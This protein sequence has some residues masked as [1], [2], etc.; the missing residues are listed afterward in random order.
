L[1]IFLRLDDIRDLQNCKLV[2]S[3]KPFYLHEKLIHLLGEQGISFSFWKI[4]AKQKW[5]LQV[6]QEEPPEPGE[7]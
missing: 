1:N 5:E 3:P 4:F 2:P 7:S 6:N